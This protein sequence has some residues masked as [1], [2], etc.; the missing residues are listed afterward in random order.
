MPVAA[1]WTVVEDGW[2]FGAGSPG[3]EGELVKMLFPNTTG[4]AR[5]EF[6]GVAYHALQGADLDASQDLAGLVAVSNILES[7]S[8]ILSGNVEKDLL[9]TSVI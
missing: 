6:R 5:G 7:L 8:G 3:W 9:S 1:G 4:V 2:A